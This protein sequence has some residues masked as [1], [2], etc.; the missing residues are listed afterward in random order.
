M[1]NKILKKIL[2]LFG[3]KAIDKNLI[4]KNRLLSEK[5]FLSVDRLLKNLF[6]KKTIN[7]LIQI[8]A[9]DGERFDTINYFIKEYNPQCLLVEPIM[10]NYIKLQKNYEDYNN[11]KFDNSAIS[12]N[13]EINYLYKVS[14]NKILNY[15]NHIPGITS[16]NKNHLIKHGV[17]NSDII[18][19]NVKSISIK[20]LLRLILLGKFLNFFQK[21]F[22]LN[23]FIDP[24]FYKPNY[25]SCFWYRL[26]SLEPLNYFL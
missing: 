24:C 11:I 16:F 4:K 5:S 21:V 26:L 6:S 17:K 18:K 14:P 13:K 12:V 23:G 2:G 19:E 10:E 22:L 15:G 3:Y 8:G 20:D 9:N 7:S 25:K 1:N